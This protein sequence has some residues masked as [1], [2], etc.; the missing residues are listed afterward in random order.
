MQLGLGS[1]DK[2]LGGGDGLGLSRCNGSGQR[3]RYAVGVCLSGVLCRVNGSAKL[4]N[5]SVYVSGA[6]LGVDSG[7]QSGH[8]AFKLSLR[9]FEISHLPLKSQDSVLGGGD[10]RVGGVDVAHQLAL[11]RV[12]RALISVDLS[13]KRLD[14]SLGSLKLGHS[15]LKRGGV[16]LGIERIIYGVDLAL[17]LGLGVRDGGVQCC[18]VVLVVENLCIKRSA[19]RDGRGGIECV[20]KLGI[21]VPARKNVTVKVKRRQGDLLPLFDDH[22]LTC[23]TV[24]AE[25]YGN[26]ASGNDLDVTVFVSFTCHGIRRCRA[27]RIITRHYDHRRTAKIGDTS[28]IDCIFSDSCRELYG[29]VANVHHVRIQKKHTEMLV[30]GYRN[31]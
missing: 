1:V 27:C 28:L 9:R 31:V 12:V 20:L 10:G 17:Q 26:G 16:C 5:G 14:V 8:C 21:R 24:N 23:H 25:V 3:G 13:Q 22:L 15:S 29:A 19:L 2:P 30:R 6:C 11:E 4:L 7:L 18:L